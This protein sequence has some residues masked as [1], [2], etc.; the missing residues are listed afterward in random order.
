MLS[1]VIN[2]M[3]L[4]ANNV[5]YRKVIA[6]SET[7]YIEMTGSDYRIVLFDYS[8]NINGG[9]V[10]QLV[11]TKIYLLVRESGILNG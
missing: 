1:L 5:P 9:G 8:A 4:N 7:W 6:C 3:K 10:R 11:V 2:V